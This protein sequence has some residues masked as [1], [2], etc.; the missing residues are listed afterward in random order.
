MSIY[1]ELKSS[2]KGEVYFNDVYR[3][4]YSTDA[5][6]Y[7]IKPAGVVIPETREDV[8][9]TVKIAAKY[10]MPV[11]ARG[12]GSGLAGESL[13]SGI[14]VDLAGKMNRVTG[15]DR[16]NGL[17][18]LEPG[19]VFESLNNYLTQTG[20]IFGPNPASGNRCTMGGM[21]ANNSTGSYYLKYGFTRDYIKSLEVV[22]SDGTL[23]EL[24]SMPEEKAKELPLLGGI[25]PIIKNNLGL[26]EKHSPK[27]KRNNAGYLV[28]GVLEKGM[29]DFTKI[30][31]G[32]EGTLAIVVS[33]TL[34]LSPRPKE[35][36]M[37]VLKFKDLL[38][39]A[40]YVP[41]IL[42]HHPMTVEIMDKMLLEFAVKANPRFQEYIGYETDAVL[43]IEFDGENKEETREKAG[44]CLKN[45]PE[46]VDY[47]EALDKKTQ[48]IFWNMRK[49]GVP[50]LYRHGGERHPTHF[51]DDAS[52]PP[53]RLAEFI[54]RAR[55]VFSKYNTFA[56]FFAHA[57]DG[58]LHISPFLNLKNRDDIS[59]MNH[60]AGDFYAIIRD[61]K[62]S[63]SGEHGDGLSRTSFLPAQFGELYKVFCEIKKAAD[64]YN[65]LNPGKIVGNDPGLV[66]KNLRF[67]GEYKFDTG[68][69]I[70]NWDNFSQ[71]VERCSGCGVCRST[72]T[73]TRM[74]P[75]FRALGSEL[76][77]TRSKSNVLR[78]ILAGRTDRAALNSR[79]FK[80]IMDLCLNCSSCH[81]D[82]PS[83]AII[84]DIVMEARARFL[85]PDFQDWIMGRID[86]VSKIGSLVPSIA[87]T[88]NSLPFTRMFVE[89]TAKVSA[90]SPMP[91]LAGRTLGARKH[92][93]PHKAS[94]KVLLYTDIY[95][96]YYNVRLGEHF[97]RLLRHLGY[98]VEPSPLQYTGLP[99]IATGQINRALWIFKSNV[100]LFEK[101]I[102]EGY[103]IIFTEPSSLFCV[104][105]DYKKLLPTERI[106]PL[107]SHIMEICDFTEGLN[108]HKEIPGKSIHWQKRVYYHRPC[109]LRVLNGHGAGLNIIS[110]IPGITI[111]SNEAGC[112]GM[113]GTF[114]MKAKNQELSRKISSNLAEYIKSGNFDLC[115]TECSSCRM[116][117]NYI[118]G[119]PVYHPLEIVSFLL[120]LGKISD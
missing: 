80:K 59:A 39:A 48:E 41:E 22:L 112:C 4:I 65:I 6:I 3:S 64:P 117:I 49:A 97:I 27:I 77:T 29:A 87:N 115:V 102:K 108:I 24:K 78:D 9:N 113:G 25:I 70:F 33:A 76:S 37:V 17:V 73:A 57:G 45:I 119:L 68:Q 86:I 106:D 103:K 46:N 107:I 36:S 114:G 31:C 12:G 104:N 63:I 38:K 34:K 15:F 13:C 58:V 26:I 95:P 2:I 94:N 66:T 1:K 118:T 53:E 61:L 110:K 44:A 88:F 21:I 40:A 18:T 56:S 54:S 111:D 30:I 93:Q 69:T 10:K 47:I 67:G 100:N 79:D 96:H 91:M 62:G 75:V 120:G 72:Q 101:K 43:I 90:D 19:L 51:I 82:C 71:E 52:V 8:I 16:E 99:L 32:S 109:H 85:K 84:S 81:A 23:L 11:A 42:K 74:C 14:V 35:K 89:R 116:Q 50:L 20:W 98:Y 60:I 5:S 7:Q 28:Q 92:H 83:G 105:N 55:E